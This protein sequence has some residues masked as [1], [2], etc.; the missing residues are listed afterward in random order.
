MHKSYFI[1][2]K[3]NSLAGQVEYETDKNDEALTVVFYI[4]MNRPVMDRNENLHCTKLS[5]K[6]KST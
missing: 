3:K 1:Y 5:M 4:L 2:E 6:S